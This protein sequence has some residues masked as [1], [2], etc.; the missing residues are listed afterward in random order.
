M[1]SDVPPLQGLFDAVKRSSLFSERCADI[2]IDPYSGILIFELV[3]PGPAQRSFFLFKSGET[4]QER[5][6]E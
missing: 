1:E 2:L 4:D 5:A 3:V 6:G